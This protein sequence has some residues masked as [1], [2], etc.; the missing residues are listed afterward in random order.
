MPLLSHRIAAL[1]QALDTHAYR[2]K[3]PELNMC[4]LNQKL[5]ASVLQDS[6]PSVLTQ[7]P[8]ITVGVGAALVLV[9]GAIN[10]CNH[11]DD[12]L[13]HLMTVGAPSFKFDNADQIFMSLGASLL[14]LGVLWAL[15]QPE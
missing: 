4:E 9:D 10:F 8:L 6:G 14:V 2:D 3:F 15:V 1:R 7:G 12:Y 5:N 11:M 13:K